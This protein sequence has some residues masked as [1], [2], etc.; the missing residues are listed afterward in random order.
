MAAIFWTEDFELGLPHIDAQHATLIGLVNDL[1]A[2]FA[3]A[4]GLPRAE[5]L[6]A[7]LETYAAGHFRAEEALMPF[8]S[9]PPAALERHRREHRA[10]IDRVAE[11]RARAP[12]SSPA[13]AADVLDFL[14]VWLVGHILGADH[15]LGRSLPGQTAPP[16]PEGEEALL[17]IPPVARVLVGALAESERRF[18]LISDSAPALIWVCDAHGRRGYYNRAW[19]DL[20]G[21]APGTSG[22]DHAPFVLAEDASRHAATLADLLARQA[23]GEHEYRLGGAEAPVWLLERV[24]PRFDGDGRFAGLVAAATDISAIKR[25]EARLADHNRTLEREVRRR[26]AELE[27]LSL[28]D[29]LTGIGN[30]RRLAQCLDDE[31]RRARRHRRPFSVVFLDLDHFKRVNDTHGHGVGDAVLAATA[32]AFREAL[33]DT[34]IAGR[35][36]GE[37]FV[38]VLPETNLADAHVIAERLRAAV[39]AVRVA[40]LA[41]PVSASAG[42][43]EWHLGE[44]GDML[45]ARADDALYEAKAAG[46]DRTCI[47]DLEGV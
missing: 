18:R 7:R 37:E 12:A 4:G 32:A 45:L 1:S 9:L 5:A 47:A 35:W 3:D 11:L 15:A 43:A 41:G 28:T 39:A 46:R 14:T 10:F 29:P 30:R 26:T 44:T 19:F 17:T 38:A 22:F 2:A 13:I 33:R 20:A 34:D 8:S 42:V 40:G 6:L 27:Q 16:E 25:S 31:T 23:A 36:G 21:V 24:R